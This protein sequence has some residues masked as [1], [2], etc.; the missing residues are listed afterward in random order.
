MACIVCKIKS[1]VYLLDP[2]SPR[3]WCTHC[4]PYAS[5]S[6][7]V[8]TTLGLLLGFI[9]LWNVWILLECHTLM[10]KILCPCS[11]LGRVLALY[12]H[13]RG[14]LC[15]WLTT[16]TSASFRHLSTSTPLGSVQSF[17]QTFGNHTWL[18]GWFPP[19]NQTKMYGKRERNDWWFMLQEYATMVQAWKASCTCAFS[20]ATYVC[21]CWAQ[22][23]PW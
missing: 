6:L 13:T 12:S 3:C 21:L 23:V 8:L 10:W 2:S 1:C 15:R 11:A 9:L 19:S 18:S 7:A 22:N 17:L 5:S 16:L 4:R 20:R 14:S